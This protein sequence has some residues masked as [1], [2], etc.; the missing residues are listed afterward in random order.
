MTSSKDDEYIMTFSK[1]DENINDEEVIHILP[2]PSFELLNFLFIYI[3]QVILIK[4]EHEYE[5]L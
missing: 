3:V 2:P 1:D 4:H 5:D